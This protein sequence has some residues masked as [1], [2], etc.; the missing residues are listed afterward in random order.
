ME[1]VETL[2]LNR[3]APQLAHPRLVE[4]P[5]VLGGLEGR[6]GKGS[7][8]ADLKALALGLV[9]VGGTGG[10]EQ[11]RAKSQQASAKTHLYARARPREEHSN[12]LV[13]GRGAFADG[14]T[15]LHGRAVRLVEDRHVGQLGEIARIDDVEEVVG[16]AGEEDD[17]PLLVAPV[18][19]DPHRVALVAL[20]AAIRGIG[21]AAGDRV[22]VVTL[23][24]HVVDP[25]PIYVKGPLIIDDFVILAAHAFVR[26][27]LAVAHDGD[28]ICT[29]QV[30]D[31]A[32]TR[33][34]HGPAA[35]RAQIVAQAHLEV[36]EKLWVFKGHLE[37]AGEHP[38]L[39]GEIG[40]VDVLGSV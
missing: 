9:F 10:V 2:V 36:R 3:K 30:R 12:W 27:F 16:H 4:I 14:V 33:K 17:H 25:H 38:D 1:I 31:D 18:H 13:L 22:H 23:D 29:R 32:A 21:D 28:C 34:D 37:H 24:L 26:L 20:H 19:G 35:Q 6:A 40:V 39:F 5:H 11:Q 7:T 15:V 8:G